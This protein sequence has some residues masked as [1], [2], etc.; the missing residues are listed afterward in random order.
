LKGRWIVTPIFFLL[1]LLSDE[2]MLCHHE[3]DENS[4]QKSLQISSKI[5][6]NRIQLFLNLRKLTLHLFCLLG[7]SSRAM[8]LLK[9]FK[10]RKKL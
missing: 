9:N 8:L 4:N 10:Q 6:P 7:G 2:Q 3:Q 5:Q 1:Q